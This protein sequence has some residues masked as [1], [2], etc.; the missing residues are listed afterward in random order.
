MDAWLAQDAIDEPYNNVESVVSGPG[1]SSEQV[2]LDRKDLS[3]TGA[4]VAQ[5]REPRESQL[6][7]KTRQ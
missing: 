1:G 7:K 3:K 4:T 2:L 6:R 5:D